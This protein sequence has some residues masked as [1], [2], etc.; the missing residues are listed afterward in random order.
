[1]YL[2]KSRSRHLKR[3]SIY[4]G[5]VICEPREVF[6]VFVDLADDLTMTKES[7]DALLSNAM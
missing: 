4:P 7:F 2:A 6:D 3:F 1:M 5:D